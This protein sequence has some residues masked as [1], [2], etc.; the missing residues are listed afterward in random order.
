M[1][2][3]EHTEDSMTCEV[4]G[5]EME[6]MDDIF[7]ACWQCPECKNIQEEDKDVMEGAMSIRQ[8]IVEEVQPLV[9]DLEEKVEDWKKKLQRES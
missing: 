5:T 6:P 1:T 8:T 7:K 2:E 3:Y 9:H 4:C